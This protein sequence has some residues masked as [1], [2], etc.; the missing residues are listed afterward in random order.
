MGNQGSAAKNRIT[1]KT[2][3]G[4]VQLDKKPWSF[5]A[6]W[7]M[8]FILMVLNLVDFFPITQGFSGLTNLMD[9]ICSNIIEFGAAGVI[10]CT[11]GCLVVME[12]LCLPGSSVFK[13]IIAAKLENFFSAFF[14]LYFIESIIFNLLHNFFKKSQTV[15]TF[16]L[17]IRVQSVSNSAQYFME[18][19]CFFPIAVV[20]SFFPK[21][22]TTFFLSSQTRNQNFYLM[23]LNISIIFES[24][25]VAL[26][27]AQFEKSSSYLRS[28]SGV[29]MSGELA[30]IYFM[31]QIIRFSFMVVLFIIVMV[32]SGCQTNSSVK[33]EKKSKEV[34]ANNN[35][36]SVINLNN[37]M[38]NNVNP[39]ESELNVIGKD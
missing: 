17:K 6:F 1:G 14:L 28:D 2:N 21:S 16:L 24:L 12:I 26:L 22:F 36:S 37:N 23:Y 35:Q 31:T 7:A 10:F 13:A 8:I 29:F 33:P 38:S 18:S 19:S 39:D 3:G 4:H 27:S 5:Y 20:S 9:R 11:F 25:I 30:A 15:S 32:K 34:S